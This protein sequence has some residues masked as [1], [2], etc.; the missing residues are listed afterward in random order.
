MYNL[1]DNHNN[2]YN[3]INDNI[4]DIW[5]DENDCNSNNG[6]LRRE[7]TN[8]NICVNN[9]CVEQFHTIAMFLQGLQDPLQYISLER[10][11]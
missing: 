9:T 2:N 7:Q 8:L 4:N 6:K 3:D 11:R 1:D 5:D 10:C